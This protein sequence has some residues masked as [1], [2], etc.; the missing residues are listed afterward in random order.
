MTVRLDQVPA[1]APRPVRPRAWLWLGVFPLLL[2]LL[3]VGGMFLFGTQALREQPVSFWGLA[4]G[5]PLLGWC[6]LS[7]GRVLLYLGQQQV[8]DGWDQA[9]EEDLIQKLRRGRRVQQVLAVSLH[10]ALR[11]P[12]AS[13]ATQLK[14]LLDG[15]KALKAQPSRQDQSVLRHSRIAGDTAE[16]PELALH[17]VLTQMLADLAPS[18]TQVPDATPL[19]L[20]LEVGSTLPEN[21]WQRVWRQAWSESG[22]R[23]ST[24]LVEEDG[25]EALDQWLDH[26]IGDQALLLVVAVQFAPQQPEGTAEAA[27]GLLFGNRLTQTVLPSMAYLHRP[28]QEREPTTDALLYAASQALDWVPLDAQSIEQTWRVGVD[29]QRDAALT[30]VLADVSIPVKHNQGFYDLDAQLGHPGKASPWLAI[31]AATQTIQSGAG[32]QFIFSGGGCVDAG[33]WSTVLTPVPSLSK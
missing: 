20:L 13:S 31:A 30:T 3:G 21:V 27:V 18:L 17:R 16:V 26:R 4:F 5:V 12:E 33:L 19:A 23:Q 9:R 25:L 15:V 1:L 2:L 14:A 7:F 29:T 24:V 32:P 10:T 11:E 6:L 8:A 22:I 28:E